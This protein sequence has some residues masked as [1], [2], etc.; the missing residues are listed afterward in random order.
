[1]LVD[2][3]RYT[4][5]VNGQGKTTIYWQCTHRPNIKNERCKASVLQSGKK[6]QFGRHSH[7]HKPK[8]TKT[9]TKKL[10]SAK[11]IVTEVIT[12]LHQQIYQAGKRKFQISDGL[13][14]SLKK[15]DQ[16][17]FRNDC[18]RSASLA[19]R[20]VGEA[21]RWRNE[22]QKILVFAN[23]INFFAFSSLPYNYSLTLPYKCLFTPNCT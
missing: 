7:N 13:P 19:K 1:M 9:Q 23:V 6:F 18:W 3:R 5:N 12:T 11:A 16:R 10:K 4:Y 14:V 15:T 20:L 2:S 21:T 8:E 22:F 17:R